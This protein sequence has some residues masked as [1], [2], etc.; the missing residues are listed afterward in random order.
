MT[1]EKLSQREKVLLV[2]LGTIIV[3][4]LFGT[5]LLGPQL[6]AFREV[7]EQ[8][9]IATAR[10]EKGRNIAASYSQEK[11][12]LRAAAERLAPLASRFDIDLGDG[13]VLVDIGL[14]AARQGVAVTLVR[15][16]VV[17]QQ[18]H[19]FELPIE[20]AVQ[21]DYR[22][23]LNFIRKVENLASL[24]ELRQIEIKALV[25][26]ENPGASP[27]AAD[28]R[29]RATFTLVLY[30]APTPE[31]KLRLETVSKWVLGR[32]NPYQAAGTRVPYPGV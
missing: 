27:A 9:R 20:F 8:L 18:E 24:S 11:E 15:P 16:G 23:V 1:W 4:Y 5:F 31:N 6:A 12:A 17:G 7:R 30:A 21:G 19:Y 29:V 14:E 2:L 3:L 32:D 25:L 26:A 13:A 28:G 10:L 22:R